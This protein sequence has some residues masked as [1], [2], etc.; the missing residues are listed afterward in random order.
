MYTLTPN[1]EVKFI[2]NQHLIGA[3]S[4]T[5]HFKDLSSRVHKLYYSGD[6][7]NTSFKKHFT[8]GSQKTNKFSY[9]I[10]HRKY[11][12]LKAENVYG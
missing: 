12:R 11:I 6:L 4:F 1:I 8:Y 5:I 10:S 9:S 7:G 3:V 2:P